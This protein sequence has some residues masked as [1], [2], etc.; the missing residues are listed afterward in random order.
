MALVYPALHDKS[1]RSF[2]QLSCLQSPSKLTAIFGSAEF[3]SSASQYVSQSPHENDWQLE[4]G[5]GN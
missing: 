4:Y 5:Q 1:E 3:Y 2:K